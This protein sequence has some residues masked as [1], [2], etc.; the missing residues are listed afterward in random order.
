MGT[1]G[2]GLWCVFVEERFRG[3]NQNI[4]INEDCQRADGIERIED[5]GSVV[6]AEPEMSIMKSMLGYECLRMD[7]NDAP[8]WA[9]EL[10]S[11]YRTFASRYQ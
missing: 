5:D 1:F 7:L 10:G 3:S 11:R 2:K 4:K 6:F 8:A 9:E